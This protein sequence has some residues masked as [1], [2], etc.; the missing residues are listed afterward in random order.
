MSMV[1]AET[2]L[3]PADCLETA[4]VSLSFGDCFRFSSFSICDFSDR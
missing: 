2:P 4:K 1:K 3:K